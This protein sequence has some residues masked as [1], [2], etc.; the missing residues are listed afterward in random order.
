M[1]VQ[2]TTIISVSLHNYGMQICHPAV[3]YL[4][5]PP[6]VSIPPLCPSPPQ[7]GNRHRL[8]PKKTATVSYCTGLQN[9]ESSLLKLMRTSFVLTHCTPKTSQSVP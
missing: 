7:G 3:L 2:Q 1:H 5:P 6:P 8:V 9:Y 4:P